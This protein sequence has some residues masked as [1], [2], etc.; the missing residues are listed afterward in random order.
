MSEISNR[1]PR[2]PLTTYISLLLVLAATACGVVGSETGPEGAQ[3]LTITDAR[4][5]EI[6]L[7]GPAERIVSMAPSNTEMLFAIGAG[8]QVVGRDEISDYPPEVLEVASIGSTYGELNTEAI[9]ALEPDLILAAD[10]TPPEQIEM[11]E[12]LGLVVFQMPNPSDFEELFT[13]IGTVGDL[14]GRSVEAEDLVTGLRARVDRVSSALEGVDTVTVFYEVDGTDPTAPWT[15]GSA[16]FQDYLIDFTGGENVAA[17]I[18][19]WGQIN[20]EDIIAR[21][22]D[23]II[24]AEGP[25]IPTTVASLSERSGWSDLSAVQEGR[26][27]AVDTNWIDRPGPRLVDAM[28]TFASAIHP[29]N[30]ERQ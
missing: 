20:L 12:E 11:L 25:W 9:L 14:T 8:A 29:E 23:V 16:T 6:S 26:V 21:D 22:P 15:T 13:T 24:F 10:L 28:E 27:Y 17:D 18:E 19:G 5:V 7:A 2:P 4:G 1:I 3:G 30:M